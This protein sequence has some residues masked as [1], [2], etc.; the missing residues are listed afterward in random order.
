MMKRS[1]SNRP[2]RDGFTLV[3]LLVALTIASVL[4]AIALPTL[5]DSMRQNSLS[6][7]ASLVKGA[8][9]NARSNA[10]RSG[11]PYGIVI[12]RRRPDLGSGSADSLAFVNA[13]YSTRLYY[14]QSPLEYRGDIQSSSAYPVRGIDTVPGTPAVNY[15]VPRFFIPRDEAGLVYAS[16]LNP[17]SPAARLVSTGTLFSVNDSDYAFQITGMQATTRNIQGV[18][19][20]AGT[21]ISFNYRDASP[22]SNILPGHITQV[23]NPTAIGENS[24]VFPAGLALE[25]PFDFKFQANPI[26][27]PLAPV[28]MIGRTVIDLSVS[29]PSSAPIAFNSQVIVDSDPSSVIPAL[30][31]DQPLNDVVVM[32]APDGRLDGIYTD[33]RVDNGTSI[34]GF[35]PTRFDP[36]TTVSFNVG[37]LD[38][39]LDN[40]DDGA[41][42]PEQLAVGTDY[43]VNTGDP[44]FATP[45]S[46]APLTPRIAPNF[47]NTDCA[48]VSI[49][50]LSGTIRLDSVASQP[51]QQ[52]LTDYYGFQ[53]SPPPFARTI[54]QARVLQ[55]RRLNSGG[56]TQ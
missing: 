24:F 48:W 10:I 25:Q 41:R 38:G 42:Y 20:V 33:V 26:R 32:F 18:P 1:L 30:V 50:P 7:A 47:A 39:V 36:S 46:P 15:N 21:E 9:I 56:T 8:F 12:E 49:Q 29:G 54:V 6:R 23:T 5:K 22:R 14:V 45:G 35:V 43:Q 19:N 40:I 44:A 13:N 3:E 53:A 55:S 16:A 2:K 17:R 52:R 27:A 11:R 51:R 28:T 31:A 37:F 34:T 4:T